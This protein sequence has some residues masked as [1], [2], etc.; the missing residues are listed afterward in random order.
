MKVCWTHIWIG[1]TLVIGVTSS[2][3]IITNMHNAGN[4]AYCVLSMGLW[5]LAMYLVSSIGRKKKKDKI[6]HNVG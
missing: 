3:G 1:M 4:Q 6:Y 2:I 5:A